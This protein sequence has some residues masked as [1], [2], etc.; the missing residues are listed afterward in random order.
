MNFY[1]LAL[2][3]G[4]VVAGSV[5]VAAWKR[6]VASGGRSLAFLMAA[7]SE[8]SLAAA[9]EAA[10]V[11]VPAKM[12]WSKIEYIGIAS[13]PLLIFLFALGFSK[14]GI[15]L[16]IVKK[17]L[18]WTIP[19]A[20]FFLAATNEFHG[21]IWAGFS[22][23][24]ASNARLLIYRH[25]PFFWVHT[26]FS[27]S[28]MIAT[29]VLL[30]RAFSRSRDIHRQQAMALLFALP[31]PYLGNIIYLT[32]GKAGSGYDYTP[33]GFAVAGFF[34]LWGIYG[35]H[36]GDLVPV[37]RERVTQSMSESLIVLDAN[38]RIAMLNPAART[39]F[40]ALGILPEG[41]PESK[42]AGRSSAEVC[43]V[44]PELA[45]CLGSP[46][47]GQKE[48]V[49]HGSARTRVFDLRLS[50]LCG[51]GDRITGWVAVLY[52]ISRLKEAEIMAVQA[53]GIAEALQ[54]AGM[55]LS[56]TLEIKQ[57][58]NLILD[59]LRHV[60]TFD[61]GAFLIAE[62]AELQIAGI[63][64]IEGS[65]ELLGG[66]IPVI[67]CGLCNL[68]VQQRR[69]L[70]MD[71]IHRED[72]LVPLP[73][74]FQVRSFLGAPI[75]FRDHV[76]G[77]LALYSHEAIGFTEDDV[78]V[79]EL[80]AGQLAVTLQNSLLFDQMNKL[81]TTDNL[82]G[83]LNR[84][85]FFEL[86]EKECERARRYKKTLALILLDIDHFKAVNDTHGHLIGDQ[87]LRGIAAVVGRS[88]RASDVLCRFGGDEFLILMPETGADEALALAERL[89]QK[90]SE[91]IIVTPAEQ[92]L[93]TVSVGVA[94]SRDGESDC[95]EKMVGRADAAMY[96]SKAGGRNKVTG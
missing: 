59:L 86:G 26:A 12:V 73:P 85:R 67:G 77:L 64:G 96:E 8:W 13:S 54:K 60:V 58:S 14:S 15:R 21:L 74:D 40:A 91:M 92:L 33:L 46:S 27:Y 61:A 17:V 42:I 9:V 19:A 83:V 5:A 20:T 76:M 32:A 43:A 25:G 84:R 35:L 47:S 22:K 89:R 38:G 29:T 16:T 4:A 23:A 62:G 66:R 11:S 82:T 50:P 36:L 65:Q 79:A 68:V 95:L 51:R 69:P 2:L 90:I 49:W 70:V 6:P 80:F 44:W 37:A 39:L 53:R 34:L 1:L 7:V 88:I 71:R 87:V 72:I 93:L 63:K 10:A 24:P 55:I 30:V 75:I 3:S 81:A 52:D 57:M 45:S 94:V 28:L 18:L 78:A 31:W 56:S 48:I 41:V